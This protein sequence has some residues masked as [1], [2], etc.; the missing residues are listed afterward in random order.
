VIESG[1]RPNQFVATACWRCSDLRNRR[2][3]CRQALRAAAMI[4]A[5]VDE[6]NR[7]LSHDLREPIRFGVGIHAAK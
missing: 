6:L 7:F 3:A 1:G 4:A 2:D 5:N